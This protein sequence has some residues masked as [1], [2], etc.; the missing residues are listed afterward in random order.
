[1]PLYFITGNRH[2]FAEIKAFVPDLEMLDLDLPEIQELDPKAVIQAKLKEA[3]AHH[4]GRFIVEDT[5]LNLDAFGGAFPGPLVKWFVKAVTT[6]G[7]YELCVK[8]GM[9]GAAERTVI[10]FADG[11]DDIHYFEGV[12]RGTI[13][14]PSGNRAFAWDPIFVP[15]G[16]TRTQGE[17][18]TD[19]KN[20]VS[21]RGKAARALRD[22]LDA[23]SRLPP[24]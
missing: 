1:M 10:G 9:F 16:E 14:A 21:Q 3:T 5:S 24:G 4:G 6:D 12:T 19:E 11:H 17:M 18:T 22:Y 7:I 8:Y 15:E 2:K 13:V 23:G 20:A